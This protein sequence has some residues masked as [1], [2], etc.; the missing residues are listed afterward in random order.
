M[1][2]GYEIRKKF[3]QFFKERGHTIIPSSSLVPHDDPS[4]LLTTAG[5]QQ[6]KPYF[7]GKK[8][9][10]GNR[11][12][13]IQKS[14][15]TSDIDEVGDE[16]HN[17]F[18]EMLGNFSFDYPKG[19]GSYFKKEAIA[20][21][22]EL[23]QDE[24][25]IERGRI[26]ASIFGGDREVPR[27]EESLIILKKF[28]FADREIGIGSREDNFWGPTGDEGPCGPTVELYVDGVE[29][30]NLV[31][32]EY[33]QD[34]EKRLKKLEAQGVDT[35]MGIERI[36]RAVQKVNHIYQ[37]D[38]FA[39]LIASIKK[40]L[41]SIDERGARIL[42]D[43]LRGSVFLIGDGVEPSNKEQGYI[44]RRLLRRSLV[45]AK[46]RN[47]PE[48]WYAEVVDEI[49]A[50]FM[51][52]YPELRENA[53]RIHE[54][55]DK[56]AEQFA[57]ALERGFKELQRQ[58][59]AGEIRPHYLHETFGFPYLAIEE[60]IRS[61]KWNVD[62]TRLRQEYERAS[63]SHK[64]IS[65]AGAK[66]KF[67]G[68][69]LL[70][71]SG[72]II[73]GSNEDK[74]RIL[75]L[76]TATHLLHQALRDTLGTF[77]RQ[78]GSDITSERLR[79]DFSFSRK[80]TSEEISKVSAIVN[81]K[82]KDDLPVF[83]QEMKREESEK[84]GALAFFKEKYGKTVSVYLIGSKDP[85]K[86]YSKELCAGPH[87]ERTGMIGQFKILKEEAVGSGIRRIKATVEP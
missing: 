65:R 54:V 26:A 30:W 60:V 52:A 37:T 15:R 81:A 87:V 76:H 62:L 40:S 44:L 27:D 80:L 85:H 16:T 10:Y 25:G 48:R 24:L 47:G 8:S 72:E 50:Q 38:L 32:N 14:F 53:R 46:T 67:G 45:L 18:F 55:V 74:R 63:F 35:G 75:R 82:I 68:H 61:Q 13:S 34:A 21:G 39:P 43:H 33:F 20:W 59:E 71:S 56:E 12:V 11:A 51:E 17:T 9:P 69:G 58:Y 3:L 57:R 19:R 77:V 23:L 70:S 31:F 86:A 79:F 22:L 5:M 84:T 64:G 28:G 42:A 66:R 49:I 29:T 6:F 73:G 41:P 1:I 7:L 36:T 83:R 4:V 2:T 78:M